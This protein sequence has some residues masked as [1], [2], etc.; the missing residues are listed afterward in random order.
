M[1]TVTTLLIAAVLIGCKPNLGR[2][3]AQGDVMF[4]GK[5]EP[6]TAQTNIVSLKFTEMVAI[7]DVAKEV[8]FNTYSPIWNDK[9]IFKIYIDA[10]TT[11]IHLIIHTE[12]NK[13]FNLVVSPSSEK[14]DVTRYQWTRGDKVIDLSEGLVN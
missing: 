12:D 14:L 7:Q 1:K 5:P 8:K 3:I 4:P 2:T 6:Y 9:G 11:P 10:G 13:Q